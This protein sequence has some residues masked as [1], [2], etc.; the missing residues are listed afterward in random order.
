MLN[1]HL[2]IA[3]SIAAAIVFVWR[4]SSSGRVSADE[5][6]PVADVRAGLPRTVVEARDRSKLLYETIRGVLQVV[7]R[8]LFDDEDTFAI[9]SRSMEDVFDELESSHGVEVRWLTVNADVLNV[10]HKPRD[11]FE[12]AAVK[13][14]AAGSRQFEKTEANVYRYA[15][16]IRL[17][18]QCLKCH[19]KLRT[20]TEDRTSGLVI[21]MPLESK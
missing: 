6:K 11:A 9:P 21:S 5:S 18:S 17:A 8:D 13:A 15:G 12:K 7:H 1:R 3:L 19:V 14:L 2:L 16:P 20:S 4:D 10:D